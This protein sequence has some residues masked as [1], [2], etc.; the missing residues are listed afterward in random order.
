MVRANSLR[1]LESCRSA[2]VIVESARRDA[3]RSTAKG[4][5]RSP[6]FLPRQPSLQKVLRKIPHRT[7]Q[8]TALPC[9]GEHV[10]RGARLSRVDGWWAAVVGNLT[11]LGVAVINDHL[12][13]IHCPPL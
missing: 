7:G 12:D 13:S 5:T 4:S 6:H 1:T 8:V 9:S 3:P 2:S 10:P 11:T